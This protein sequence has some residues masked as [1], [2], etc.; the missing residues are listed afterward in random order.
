MRGSQ[1]VE[2]PRRARVGSQLY[3]AGR[4]VGTVLV[5]GVAAYLVIMTAVI[6]ALMSAD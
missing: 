5:L 2:F 4:F 3:H 1:R 6:A